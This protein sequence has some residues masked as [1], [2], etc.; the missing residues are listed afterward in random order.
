MHLSGVLLSPE[1]GSRDY[2]RALRVRI[3]NQY[4]TMNI[5]SANRLDNGK[6]TWSVLESM[7]KSVVLNSSPELLASLQSDDVRGRP[8]RLEGRLYQRQ[9]V[10]SWIAFR[11]S[12]CR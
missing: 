1:E 5:R 2:P 11:H 7:N 10:L 6:R 4:W 3:D 8:L 12:L 9:R